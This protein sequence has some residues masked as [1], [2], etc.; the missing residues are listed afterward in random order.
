MGKFHNKLFGSITLI[1][2]T[3][4]CCLIAAGTCV[5]QQPQLGIYF[6]LQKQ[7]RPTGMCSIFDGHLILHGADRDVTAVEYCLETAGLT[8]DDVDHIGAYMRP[9]VRLGRRLPYRLT[10]PIWVS[11]SGRFVF[12][13]RSNLLQRYWQL[14]QPQFASF[15]L[16]NLCVKTAGLSAGCP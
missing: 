1:V 14:L 9:L 4:V 6:D 5:A 7:Y 15:A 13:S 16:Q 8:P 10:Q 12:K 3:A 11:L 2:L